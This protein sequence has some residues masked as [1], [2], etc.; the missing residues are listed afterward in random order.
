MKTILRKEEKKKLSASQQVLPTGKDS[1]N[2]HALPASYML[3]INLR[4]KAMT[5]IL[6]EILDFRPSP[7]W[8]R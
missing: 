8:N 1:P 5:P 2:C 4:A 6:T 3:E 7:R